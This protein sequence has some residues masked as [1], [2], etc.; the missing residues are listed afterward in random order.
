M[1][2]NFK[3]YIKIYDDLMPDGLCEQILDELQNVNFKQHSFYKVRED[4]YVS[5]GDDLYTNGDIL[6]SDTLIKPIIWNSF[7]TYLQ[8]INLPWFTGWEGYTSP[9][10]NRYPVGTNMREHCDHIHDI[11]DG[12]RKG[13]PKLTVLG[14]LNDDYSGGDLV[15]FTDEVY[16]LKAGQ[17]MVFPSNFLFPHR[18]ETVTEGTRYS[19]ASWAY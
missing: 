8:E 16:E 12:T 5:F 3:D 13:V 15:F 10:W 18:V 6:P 4:S 11:F 9:K 19:F 7:N 14:G 2:K 17:L 1:N